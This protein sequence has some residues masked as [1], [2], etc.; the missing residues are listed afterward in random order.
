MALTIFNKPKWLFA[1]GGFLTALGIGLFIASVVIKATLLPSVTRGIDRLRFID[2]SVDDDQCEVALLGDLPCPSKRLKALA[3]SSAEKFETCMS[4]SQPESKA[5]ASVTRWCGR[6]D[7]GCDKPNV[8]KQGDK[9]VYHFFSVLNPLDVLEGRPAQLKEMEPIRITKLTDKVDM[10]ISKIRSEGRLSFKEASMYTLTEPDDDVLL[11]QVITVPNPAM[12]SVTFDNGRNRAS[13]ES[14]HY[15]GAAAIFYSKF[16]AT[17]R[18]M[19]SSIPA[20]EWFDGST[21]INLDTLIIDQFISGE[22]TLALGELLASPACPRLVPLLAKG[23]NA[24]LPTDV[25]IAMMCHDGYRNNIG[26]SVFG[27]LLKASKISF[28][29]KDAPFFYE[30]DK[31]CADAS[32]RPANS[33]YLNRMCPQPVGSSEHAACIAPSLDRMYVESLFEDFRSWSNKLASKSGGSVGEALDQIRSF[34]LGDCRTRRNLRP[35]SSAICDKLIEQ[36]Q[37]LGRSA[38]TTNNPKWK[39]VKKSAGWDLDNDSALKL[40]PYF[41]NGTIRDL[42]G[43]GFE[44]PRKDANGMQIGPQMWVSSLYENG[45]ASAFTNGPYV[46]AVSSNSGDVNKYTEVSVN[47]GKDRPAVFTQSCAF[48]SGCMQSNL[49]ESRGMCQATPGVCQPE[50]VGGQPVGFIPPRMF[51]KREVQRS[52]TIF[53]P[54]T[55]VKAE[56]SREATEHEWGPLKVHKWQLNSINFALHS[57]EAT[58]HGVARG[59]DCDSPRGAKNIGY[60]LSYKIPHSSPRD[61]FVPMYLSHPWFKGSSLSAGTYDPMD[62]LKIIPCD[63]CPA[64]RDWSSYLYTEPETGTHVLGTT[65][66]QMNIRLSS[67]MAEKSRLHGTKG[68]NRRSL[69]TAVPGNFDLLIPLFWMDRY[70]H[71]PLYQAAKLAAI[72]SLPRTINVMF[73]A[74][75]SAGLILTAIGGWIINKARKDRRRAKFLLESRES[76][77]PQQSLG[78]SDRGST[79][80]NSF[81]ARTD[82]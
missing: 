60:H 71:A 78:E 61:L 66:M 80:V 68:Q 67:N 6:G 38:L 33:C 55:F 3:K 23:L 52:H 70:D 22:F 43:F 18:N 24:T 14:F 8:C 53:D 35:A 73:G 25:A 56:F 20:R 9:F 31:G 15:I 65:K 47:V 74:F 19:T 29:P 1:I 79:G 72:Q 11:D 48:D 58:G 59:I 32:D 13:S 75:L 46:I 44:K 37:R 28:T 30:F 57:C 45:T 4:D 17:V 51:L 50:A 21:A 64:D 27:P 49:F 82:V 62:K 76:L 39:D 26:F 63:S 16:E 69:K 10:N 5:L 54:D 42:M 34:L 41:F 7:P 40:Y 77:K 36:L 81:E 12:F 2:D